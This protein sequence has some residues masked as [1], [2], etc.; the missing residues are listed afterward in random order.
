[1]KSCLAVVW[2]CWFLLVPLCLAQPPDEATVLYNE[3]VQ[4]LDAGKPFDALEAFTEALARKPG[5]ADAYC[6][7]GDAYSRTSRFPLAIEAYSQAIKLQPE[8][9]SALSGRGFAYYHSEQ[10]EP[11]REDLGCR[12]QGRLQQG[13]FGHRLLVR[14][15]GDV[16]VQPEVGPT[17][18]ETPGDQGRGGGRSRNTSRFP[19]YQ[20]RQRCASPAN[21]F[22]IADDSANCRP[23]EPR[24]L[25]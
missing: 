7:K 13:G 21:Q 24:G 14:R 25:F 11:A 17:G 23:E 22:R 8:H 9:A 2:L 5:F 20:R 19:A 3:G 16:Q 6:G 4:Y 12:D 15:A 18:T 10:F 1:M